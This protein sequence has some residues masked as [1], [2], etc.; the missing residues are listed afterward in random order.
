M[1][2][3]EPTT[4][5]VGTGYVGRRVLESFDSGDIIGLSRSAVTTSKPVLLFDLDSDAH[6]PLQLPDC[7]RVLYTVAP[8]AD[9]E[10]DVRLERFLA[11]LGTKPVAFVYISTTGVYGDRGGGVVDEQAAPAPMTARARR[12]TAAERVLQQ[13]CTEHS[14]RL[15]ILRAP[16]IYG[17]G[18]LGLGRIRD[19]MPVLREVDANPGNRIHADDLARCCI[20]ALTNTAATGIFNVGDGDERSATW[21]ANEVARQAGLAAPPEISRAE[22]RSAFSARRLSFLSESRRVDTQRMR[23]VLGVTPQYANAEDGIRASLALEAAA[24]RASDV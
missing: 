24:D 16:G 8:A 10:Q 3:S 15:C 7:Y 21:F 4:I 11:D 14:V 5:V 20:A 2:A 12:R 19:G 1:I 22:A 6:L 13:W 17:P 18:R 23:E 9:A